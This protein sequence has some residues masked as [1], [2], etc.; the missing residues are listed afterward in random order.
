MI[1]ILFIVVNYKPLRY[2]FAGYSALNRAIAGF[3]TGAR[4]VGV[5]VGVG[6]QPQQPLFQ[7]HEI[8]FMGLHG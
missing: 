6:K 2:A 1:E 8:V 5:G 4:F 3:S 7:F